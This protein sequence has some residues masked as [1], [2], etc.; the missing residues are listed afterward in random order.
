MFIVCGINHLVFKYKKLS[1]DIQYTV[2]LKLEM[3]EALTTRT[4][5]VARIMLVLCQDRSSQ[6]CTIC[7]YQQSRTPQ[8]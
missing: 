3:V 6:H 8:R 1:K 5:Y 7:I 4:D 2:N